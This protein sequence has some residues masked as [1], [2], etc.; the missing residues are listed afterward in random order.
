M[1]NSFLVI[2]LLFTLAACGNN[3]GKGSG[4][5][6]A[7][8]PSDTTGIHVNPAL[9]DPNSNM[10]DTMKMKDSLRVKDTT[11]KDKTG[12]KSK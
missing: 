8:A 6:T 1:N 12:V 9:A 5:D 3:S 4:S 10:A 11:I 2:V 7:T